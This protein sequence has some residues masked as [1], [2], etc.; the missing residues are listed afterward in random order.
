[1]HHVRRVPLRVPKPR[2][3][4]LPALAAVAVALAL[5]ASALAG[6]FTAR[7]YAPNH[8][9]NVGNWRITVTATRG[10]QKLSGRVYYRFLYNGAVVR[11]VPGGRFS[12]GV[13]HDT[14]VWPK[15]AVG[16]TITLQTVVVTGY[17]TDY[18]NWWIKVR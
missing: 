17:G 2:S 16:H 1:M 11:T 15:N 18:L 5:P 6:G 13:W 7:L 14:L 9:P 12:H 8:Q 3:V 4:L 10:A